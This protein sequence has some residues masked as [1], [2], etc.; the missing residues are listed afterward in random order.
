[1]SNLETLEDQGRAALS[2]AIRRRVDAGETHGQIAAS[3]G[4]ARST[5]TKWA[6]GKTRDSIGSA[7]LLVLSAP[8]AEQAQRE[9]A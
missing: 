2:R 7:I 1:M 3:V 9:A 6:Q 8:A 5:V 4:V